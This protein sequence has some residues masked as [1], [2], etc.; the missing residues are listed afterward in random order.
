MTPTQGYYSIIQFCPDLGRCE[1]ANVGVLLFCP[2][3]GYLKAMTN[4]SNNRIIRFF[5]PD[6]HDWAQID[7]LK[8]GVVDR[9]E[10]ESHWIKSLADLRHFIA[11]H[12]NLF[13]FT[14]PNPARVTNPDHDLQDLFEELVCDPH[15]LTKA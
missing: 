9:V 3:L 8:Q 5:G 4:P 10:L 6:S 12:A 11:L 2:K 13:Q 15:P 14:S 7:V 1:A